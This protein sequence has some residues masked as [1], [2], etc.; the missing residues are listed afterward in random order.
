MI[1]NVIFMQAI[2]NYDVIRVNDVKP[3]AVMNCTFFCDKVAS[4]SQP[5]E[6]RSPTG[7]FTG[8]L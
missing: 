3:A 5:A 8:P 2:S 7:V 4:L 1:Q 6:G